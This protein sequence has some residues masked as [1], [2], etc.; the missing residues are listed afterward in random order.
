KLGTVSSPVAGKPIRLTLDTAVQA[1]ADATL[2]NVAPPA[3]IVALQPS[4]GKVL[5]VANSAGA[6]GDIALTG[7]YPAGSTFK[8]ATYAAALRNDPALT[9]DA[10]VDCPATV[11]VDGRTFEN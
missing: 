8:I 10:Q 11:T 9:A 1:A 7:Q 4:T 5:A 6:P 3:S 2:A